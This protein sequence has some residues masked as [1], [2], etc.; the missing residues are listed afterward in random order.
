MSDDSSDERP[1]AMSASSTG[2]QS[3]GPAGLLARVGDHILQRQTASVSTALVALLI[4]FSACNSA[5][6]DT[7]SNLRN[8]AEDATGP[9]LLATGMTFVIISG[10]LDLSVGSV[11]VF[12]SVVSAKLM[13]HMANG[14]GTVLVGLVVALLCGVA[15]GILNGY[16]IARLRLSALIVTLGTLGAA[17][18]LAEV[19]SNGSDIGTVPT[20]LGNTVGVGRVFAVPYLVWITLLV[21]VV[22]GIVL[23][24][25]RFGIRT[26]AIGSNE[27]G[28][29]R[30]G[31]RVS[32]HQIALYALSGCLAGLAA[33]LSLAQFGGTSIAGH[34][35][36]NLQAITAVILGGTSLYGGVGAMFGTVI[37]VFIPATLTNGF[38]IVGLSSSWQE[39][40]VGAVLVSAIYL[41]R[42]RRGR[43]MNR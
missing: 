9:M 5:A 26:Y 8:V 13:E 15:W 2:Q 6:F 32:R 41:D 11:L 25:T 36:D 24:G 27:E 30:A 4:L 7:W 23:A 31:L 10:G 17:Q 39:V 38:T 18:G 33:F 1:D 28:A 20:V 34:D 29:R 43:R 14:W 21:V 12:A 19:I 16:L 37:G 3:S 40:A 42:L 35:S 22:A